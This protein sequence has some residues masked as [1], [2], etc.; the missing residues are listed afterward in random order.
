M[1]STLP[2]LNRQT[3]H[4]IKFPLENL[5][6]HFLTS[7]HWHHNPCHAIVIIIITMLVV[8]ESIKTVHSFL[9][10]LPPT[11]QPIILGKKDFLFLIY[12]FT[13]D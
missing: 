12:K 10:W 8:S 5:F 9:H 6:G 2:P 7:S 11:M 4:R 13:H 1:K 3:H